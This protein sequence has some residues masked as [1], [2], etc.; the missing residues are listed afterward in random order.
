MNALA[1]SN[2]SN[3]ANSSE[4]SEHSTVAGQVAL[5]N[6]F[7]AQYVKLTGATEAQARSAYM[8]FETL[9]ERSPN[10]WDD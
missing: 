9:D 7:I 2:E 10:L 6:R 1:T 3:T 8:Y 4:T 5:E